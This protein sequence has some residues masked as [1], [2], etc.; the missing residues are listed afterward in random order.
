[1]F[2]DNDMVLFGV[3]IESFKIRHSKTILKCVAIFDEFVSFRCEM[4]L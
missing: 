2:F 3:C 1:M 4:K